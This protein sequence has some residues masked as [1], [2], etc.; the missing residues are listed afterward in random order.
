M[1]NNLIGYDYLGCIYNI[2]DRYASGYSVDTT[3]RLFDL[4]E[5]DT[6]ITILEREYSYPKD[7]IGT[8]VVLGKSRIVEYITE[9]TEE[10]YTKMSIDANL[11]G[12]YGLFSA[13]VSTKFSASHTSSSYFYHAEKSS[14]I[15]SYKL[16]LDLD[17]AVNNL[18]Q[19]FKNDVYNK[20]NG[21]TYDMTAK[22][23]VEKYGTHFLYEAIFGGRLSYSQSF[24]KLTHSDST[25]LESKVKASYDSYSGKIS[26]DY[27]TYTL[28]SK[29]DSNAKYSCIGGLPKTLEQGYEAWAETVS[30]GNFVLVDFTGENG[31]SL[32]RIS[33]LVVD[34]DDR[35]N[36]ID[37][38]IQAVLNS[39]E[40]PITT[41]LTTKSE[42]QEE[43]SKGDISNLELDS[44]PSDDGR[45]VVGFAGKVNNSKGDFSRIAVCYLNMS[46][47]KRIWEV[48]G[49]VDTFNRSDYETIGEVPPGC[50]LTGIGLTGKDKDFSQMVLH[51][52][53]LTPDN[54]TYNYLDNNLQ[55]DG[56]KRQNETAPDSGYESEFNPGSNNGKVI[57]GIGVTYRN[58]GVKSVKLYRNILVESNN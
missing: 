17:Y 38:A 5:A 54:S 10:L 24:S 21:S 18:D 31:D 56:F 20:T 40:I 41:K 46:T 4:P 29:S 13:E 44:G 1:A 35:K 55:S 27:E 43:W 53:E 39:G 42:N 32:K 37:A 2:Y 8:P 30:D 12:S 33:E 9:S 50:V 15:H 23:L 34:D 51:Y 45:V 25:K 49:N 6:V 26:G 28:E 22:E 14:Y 36:E 52:Q 19:N 57:T 3:K 11:K 48:F 7:A 58:N 16:I 47:G